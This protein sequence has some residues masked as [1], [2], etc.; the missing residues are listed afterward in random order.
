M[1]PQEQ[2]IIDQIADWLREIT[3][4]NGYN[5]NAG[6]DVRTEE[7]RDPAE[8]ITSTVL[9]VI[10]SDASRIED[11]HWALT[12]DIE[13]ILPRTTTERASARQVLADIVRAL[14][15]RI[16]S[17]RAIGAGVT[18]TEPTARRIDRNTSGSGYQTAAYTLVVTYSDLTPHPET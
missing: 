6:L 7:W 13:I 5:G 2:L 18:A 1:I 3:T 4:A 8:T 9:T 11:K 15:H 14:N 17:W 10:D 12:V 16:T